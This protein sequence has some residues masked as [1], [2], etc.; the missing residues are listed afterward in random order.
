MINVF[1]AAKADRSW[2]P[3]QEIYCPE[4]RRMVE[5]QRSASGSL[6]AAR[7]Y[8][9]NLGGM[10]DGTGDTRLCSGGYF[11]GRFKPGQEDPG[12]AFRDGPKRWGWV[13][14]VT[15]NTDAVVTVTANITRG[16]N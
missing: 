14:T 2:P 11:P 15:S 13:N 16:D 7:H 4:C 3:G 9:F 8:R 1:D 12:A 6:I 5:A 10:A